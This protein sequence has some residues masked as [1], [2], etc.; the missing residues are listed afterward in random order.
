MRERRRGLGRL[1]VRRGAPLFQ[2]AARL[3]G[4][5][6][7]EAQYPLRLGHVLPLVAFDHAVGTQLLAERHHERRVRHIPRLLERLARH[8]NPDA[9]GIEAASR[10]KGAVGVVFRAARV[11]LVATKPLGHVVELLSQ[12]PLRASTLY[13]LT[14]HPLEHMQRIAQPVVPLLARAPVLL[15]RLTVDLRRDRE[16]LTTHATRRLVAVLACRDALLLCI[17]LVL[18]L[19][20]AVLIVLGV[21]YRP[22]DPA[23]AVARRR[24]AHWAHALLLAQ[25]DRDLPLVCELARRI[26][27]RPS[28]LRAS[29]AV[30]VVHAALDGSHA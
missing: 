16:Q 30:Q 22:L 24:V 3:R 25:R 19:E 4:H 14:A 5:V 15:P 7:G 21:E 27:V 11:L 26:A 12:H 1:I 10:S 17:R 6:R 8:S 2:R 23:A 20:G 28:G 13:R 9:K 18:T 29:C